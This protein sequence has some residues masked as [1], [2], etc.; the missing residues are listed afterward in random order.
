MEI[1][2]KKELQN[3]LLKRKEI[4]LKIFNENGTPKK[5]NLFKEISK[6]FKTKETHIDIINIY[7]QTGSLY[8]N[9]KIF[10]YNKPIRD[11][12]KEEPKT[13]EKTETKGE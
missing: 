10:I 8:S 6:K 12:K 3:D 13:E 11:E 5:E 2:I 9:S 4:E 1:E 7:Q